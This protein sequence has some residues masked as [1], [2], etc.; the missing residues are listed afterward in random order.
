MRL[1]TLMSI[2]KTIA[3]IMTHKDYSLS[4]PTTRLTSMIQL[5]T[6]LLFLRGLTAA[7]NLDPAKIFA[8]RSGIVDGTFCGPVLNHFITII[9]YGTSSQGVDFWLI[10]NSWGGNWGE[11]G[12]F[13][14]LR[15]MDQGFGT[16]GIY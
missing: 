2:S 3:N 15:T 6:W 16:C 14:M 7:L 4:H 10:R 9:G 1:V 8:Y 11:D 12:Y 5:H 13:R